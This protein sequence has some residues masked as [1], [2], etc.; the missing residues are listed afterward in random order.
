MRFDPRTLYLREPFHHKTCLGSSYRARS[1]TLLLAYVPQADCDIIRCGMVKLRHLPNEFS[2]RPPSKWHKLLNI[3]MGMDGC[4][5]FLFG[6]LY[7]LMDG[8]IISTGIRYTQRGFS[9]VRSHYDNAA[10]NRPTHST[11]GYIH[12]AFHRK[13]F[14]LPVDPY[15]R[16]FPQKQIVV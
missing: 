1:F 10:E 8:H 2:L 11:C 12:K 15:P 5:P 4:L 6:D 9:V 13:P 3:R 7:I 16:L 14:F